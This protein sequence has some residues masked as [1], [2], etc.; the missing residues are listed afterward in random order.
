[1]IIV[2]TSPKKGY[3]HAQ[4]WESMSALLEHA[5][6]QA[7]ESYHYEVITDMTAG[8]C[9]IVRYLTP[10]GEFR[11]EQKWLKPESDYKRDHMYA[12]L[13]KN[14]DTVMIFDE[15]DAHRFAAKDHRN[16]ILNMMANAVADVLNPVTA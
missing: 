6:E 9:P 4:T 10:D 2:A 8:L 15:E 16:R 12:Q 7:G 11:R 5:K 13:W 1:M 3:P 14:S